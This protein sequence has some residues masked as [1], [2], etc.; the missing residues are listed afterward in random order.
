MP[1]QETFVCCSQKVGVDWNRWNQALLRLYVFPVKV[2]NAYQ[3][4]SDFTE[5]VW[6]MG[7]DFRSGRCCILNMAN[8][9]V[10]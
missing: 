8:I 6:L 2:V 4:L 9:E 1:T 5:G 7:L 10:S 3:I